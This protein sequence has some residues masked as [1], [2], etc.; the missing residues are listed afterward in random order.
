MS[1]SRSAGCG[2]PMIPPEGDISSLTLPSSSKYSRKFTQG[3]GLPFCWVGFVTDFLSPGP[4]NDS[5][6]WPRGLRCSPGTFPSRA[7]LWKRTMLSSFTRWPPLSLGFPKPSCLKRFPRDSG[8]GSL[9]TS[10]EPLNLSKFGEKSFLFWSRISPLALKGGALS[11]E[12]GDLEPNP[13]PIGALPIWDSWF[14]WVSGLR[15]SLV[16]GGHLF[17]SPRRWTLTVA[18][19]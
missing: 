19:G 17:C 18:R 9:I 8:T 2:F 15:C 1:G 16:A 11:P 14:T 6:G 4:T 3:F 12:T 7:S 10:S 5:A 13:M